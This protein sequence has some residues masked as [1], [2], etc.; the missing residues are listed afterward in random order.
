MSESHSGGANLPKDGFTY[1][2]QKRSYYFY[3]NEKP[4]KNKWKEVDG[5]RYYFQNNT[6]AAQNTSIKIKRKYFLFGED[7]RLLTGKKTR[8]VTLKNHKYR[9]D[10]NGRAVPGWSKNGKYYFDKTGKMMTGKV[11]I[12]GTKC[13]FGPDGRYYS[14]KTNLLWTRDKKTQFAKKIKKHK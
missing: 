5:K 13:I 6:R 11:S 4:L 2:R 12:K 1:N 9:V 10:K 7:A 8:I 14:K 3:D